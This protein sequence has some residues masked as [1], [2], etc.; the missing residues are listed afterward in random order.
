MFEKRNKIADGD[1]K[2]VRTIIRL[3]ELKK[4]GSRGA[5]DRNN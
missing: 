1:N 2:I 5:I 4:V 3:E